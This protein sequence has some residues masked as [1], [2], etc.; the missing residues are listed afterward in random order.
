MFPDDTEGMLDKKLASLVNKKQC[1]QISK[2]LNC[3]THLYLEV[4][5]NN[6]N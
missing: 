1:Y 2:I 5:R 4:I 3:K 6:A